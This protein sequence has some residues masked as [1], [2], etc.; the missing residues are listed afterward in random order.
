[1]YATLACAY[2]WTPDQIARLTPAQI[3]M[4]AAVLSEDERAA[5]T[6]KDDWTQFG[7]QRKGDRI[8]APPDAPPGA[9]DR[10]IEHRNKRGER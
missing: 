2:H 1:M 3:E 8:I 9:L 7:L 6:V 10:Y 4:L 5:D